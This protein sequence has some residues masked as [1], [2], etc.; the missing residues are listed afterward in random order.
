M[1]VS[2]HESRL[3]GPIVWN[4]RSGRAYRVIK[5]CFADA[6]G[7]FGLRIIHFSIQGNHLHLIVE[8]DSSA[9]LSRGMHGLTIRVAK[10]LNR[11]MARKGHVFADHYHSRLL[12][13]PTELVNAIAYVLA[14]HAHHFGGTPAR[15]PY[16]SA[17]LDEQTREIV[18]SH[19]RTWLLRSGW[20][21]ARTRPQWLLLL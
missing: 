2:S 17:A 21:R 3:T 20:R 6:L 1:V 15:D 8:A 11:L 19:P 9:A 10:A 14:N 5:Q 13:T 16:S 4:L 18:L 7:R 12:K